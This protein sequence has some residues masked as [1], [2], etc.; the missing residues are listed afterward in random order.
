MMVRASNPGGVDHPPPSN[1]EV[2]ERV[3]LYLYPPYLLPSRVVP[4]QVKRN[5][6]SFVSIFGPLF[7]AHAGCTTP[8]TG[9]SVYGHGI[10]HLY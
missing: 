6:S 4:V 5:F 10:G 3:E 8:R 2:K 9:S 7:F 1:A